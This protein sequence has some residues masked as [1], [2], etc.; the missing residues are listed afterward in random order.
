MQKQRSAF[1]LGF[2]AVC[3]FA[4][5]LPMARLALSELDPIY[6]GMGRAFVAA[7]LAGIY[8]LVK[9]VPFP[10]KK[11]IGPL[12]IVSFGISISFPLLSSY[13][14]QH[15]PATHA[16]IVVGLLPLATAYWA[17]LMRD[18]KPSLS[19]WVY[20][21]FG[22]AAVVGY[23]LYRS[24]GILHQADILLLISVFLGG[25]GYA[26]GAVTTRSLGGVQVMCWGLVFSLPVQALFVIPKLLHGGFPTAS[27]KVW[28]AMTCLI[29]L[30]QLFGMMLWYKA[31]SMG[32]IA[33]LSQIQLLQPFLTIILA[34]LFFGERVDVVTCL[35]AIAVVVSIYMSRKSVVTLKSA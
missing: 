22:C 24:G 32:S 21:L 35:A 10:Q 7:I 12:L 19:F 33:K 25:M 34:A 11:F 17:S 29:F 30:S 6:V 18:E 15:V 14:L 26:Y 23:S 1:V 9:R 31:L 13:A 3:A 16:S 2:I 28:V 5:G 4:L 20:S 27:P 8:L